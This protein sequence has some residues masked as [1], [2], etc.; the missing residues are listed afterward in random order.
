[1]KTKLYQLIAK[2][3]WEA[4]EAPVPWESLRKNE[5]AEFVTMAKAAAE[6]IRD[7]VILV[8]AK[9]W[10]GDMDTSENMDSACA[11]GA[12]CNIVAVLSGATL[13]ETPKRP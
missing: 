4:G 1:M 8:E 2:A 6:C 10:K 12:C 5:Q 7:E 11:Y 13:T 3:I 9:R